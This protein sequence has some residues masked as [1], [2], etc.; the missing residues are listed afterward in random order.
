MDQEQNIMMLNSQL[1][2]LHKEQ[3][4]LRN[5]ITILKMRFNKRDTALEVED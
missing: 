4:A 3:I 2:A 5:E 1:D